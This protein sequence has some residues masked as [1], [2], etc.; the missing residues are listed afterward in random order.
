[1]N[2]LRDRTGTNP[3]TDQPGLLLGFSVLSVLAA[4][5]IAYFAVGGTAPGPW[6]AAPGNAL[7][8]LNFVAWGLVF[9]L[10]YYFSQRSFVFRGFIW[11]CQQLSAPSGRK[12]ALVWFALL[13][14]AG[15]AMLL[16]GVGLL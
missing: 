9:L 13:V 6:R 1:M 3:S 12:V 15:M 5:L 16:T 8:G 7:L 2:R 4:L 10:S 11:F 14:F